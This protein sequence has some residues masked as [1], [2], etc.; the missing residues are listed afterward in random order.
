MSIRKIVNAVL[1][2]L[3]FLLCVGNVASGVFR[4]TGD[5]DTAINFAAVAATALGFI[6]ICTVLGSPKDRHEK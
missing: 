6:F 1:A 5:R 4:L 2:W 3:L